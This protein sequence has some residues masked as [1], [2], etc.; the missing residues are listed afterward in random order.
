M[1][2]SRHQ[3]WQ[4]RT[5]PASPSRDARP[6]PRFTHRALSRM[7]SPSSWEPPAPRSN[8]RSSGALPG[9]TSRLPAPVPAS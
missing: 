1:R 4:G 9:T 7:R 2:V 5:I 6:L 3:W 8:W